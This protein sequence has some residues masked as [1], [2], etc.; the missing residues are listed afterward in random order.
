[1]MG[2]GCLHVNITD[3]KPEL[4]FWMPAHYPNRWKTST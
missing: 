4:G 3:G 2:F 1:M